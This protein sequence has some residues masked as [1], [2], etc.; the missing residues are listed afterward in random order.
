MARGLSGW[1]YP[2]IWHAIHFP[3]VQY[4]AAGFAAAFFLS[5]RKTAFWYLPNLA[6]KRGPGC[7]CPRLASA[8]PHS[9]GC[10]KFYTRQNHCCSFSCS[11]DSKREKR[12]RK[13]SAQEN[14]VGGLACSSILCTNQEARLTLSGRFASS[15]NARQGIRA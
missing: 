15:T 3:N 14:K 7:I 13:G 4:F 12:C 8:L 11:L 5:M 10:T 1:Q 2:W 9:E 6:S